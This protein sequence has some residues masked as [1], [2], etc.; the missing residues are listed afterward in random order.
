MYWT[1]IYGRPLA[2]QKALILEKVRACRC[3]IPSKAY[4]MMLYTASP[5]QTGASKSKINSSPLVQKME[6]IK[7]LKS[8]LPKML[9]RSVLVGKKS[10]WPYLGPSEAIFSMDRKNPKKCQKFV[11]FPWSVVSRFGF[12][13]L[14]HSNFHFG[15]CRLR[16]ELT[17]EPEAGILAGALVL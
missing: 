11:Y 10:S 9:A 14:Q 4:G 15:G 7:I 16:A 17:S 5:R 8:V 2:C 13:P 12:Q 6:T 3:G 1:R